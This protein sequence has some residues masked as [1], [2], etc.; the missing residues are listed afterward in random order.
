MSYSRFPDEASLPKVERVRREFGYVIGAG[1]ALHGLRKLPSMSSA[2]W[3][4]NRTFAQLLATALFPD[5]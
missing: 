3:T 4:A 2:V 1:G 5:L